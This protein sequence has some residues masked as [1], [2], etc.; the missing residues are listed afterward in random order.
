MNDLGIIRRMFYRTGDLPPALDD[1]AIFTPSDI[2]LAAG[3]PAQ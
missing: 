2:T 3:S 1:L